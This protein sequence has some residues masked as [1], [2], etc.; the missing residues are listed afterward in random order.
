M[1][2]LKAH[3]APKTP[4]DNKKYNPSGNPKKLCCAF[5]SLRI[6]VLQAY[7]ILKDQ[8][9]GLDK[10]VEQRCLRLNT[11]MILFILEFWKFLIFLKDNKER[12][13]VRK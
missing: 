2:Q 3:H 6:P 9:D 7:H 8:K 10:V 13:N 11:H 1:C 5:G 4:G 12:K